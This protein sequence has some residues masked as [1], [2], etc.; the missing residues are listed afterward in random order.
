L[1]S[2]APA[3]ISY[4]IYDGLAQIPPFDPGLDTDNPPAA[5]TEL[6]RLLADAVDGSIADITTRDSLYTA[7][8]AFLMAISKLTLPI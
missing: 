5:V 2:L 7:F 3:N 6:R 1:D 4:T 8:N